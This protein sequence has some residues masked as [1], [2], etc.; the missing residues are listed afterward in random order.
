MK[1]LLVTLRPALLLLVVFTVLT[2]VVYPA[3]IT[4]AAHVVPSHAAEVGQAFTSPAY[5]WSRPSGIATFPYDART[6][7]GSNLGPLNP[8]LADAVKARV[9]ALRA[10]DPANTAPV[11]V[12]L[13][14]ASGSGLDPDL[15]PAAA[16]Y[17]VARVA[18]ARGRTADELRRLVDTHVEERTLGIL[19]E[20]RVDVVR[21]N[22]ALD[23]L[24][25]PP[26]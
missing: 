25:G 22:R 20:R 3:L 18:R 7:S 11:P 8:A 17:Q 10:A 21:L 23:A 16:Y 19:G 14:T 2:G 5:F 9:D 6:S 1:D 15:S 24:T 26:R 4:A 13:V 12:D